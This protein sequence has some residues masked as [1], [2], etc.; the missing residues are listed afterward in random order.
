M[1]AS[2]LICLAHGSEETEAVTTIDLLVRA[3]ID[4]TVASAATDG[5][6]TLTYSRSVKIVADTPKGSI[7]CTASIAT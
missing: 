5:A 1:N 6:L 4:V 2:A 7:C 3:E